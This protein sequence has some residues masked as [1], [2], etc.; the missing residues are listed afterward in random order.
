[1]KKRLCIRKVL[2][3]L[4]FILFV[5]LFFMLS[6]YKCSIDNESD[7]FALKATKY[8]YDLP[9]RIEFWNKTKIYDTDSDWYGRENAIILYKN[10]PLICYG[11]T[12][13]NS[14]KYTIFDNGKYEIKTLENDNIST[15]ISLAKDR[16][17]NVHFL[18]TKANDKNRTL[19]KHVWFEANK[20]KSEI[21]N[22]KKMGS[23]RNDRS[24]MFDRKNILH[25]VYYDNENNGLVYGYKS[26]VKWIFET[27][28]DS[29][30]SGYNP[31]LNVNSNDRVSI[32]Y[33]EVS[34]DKSSAL[35]LK[36]KNKLGWQSEIIDKCSSKF[37]IHR[38]SISED[39]NTQY[40]SYCYISVEGL[41]KLILAY[42]IDKTWKKLIVEESELN[43]S[44]SSLKINKNNVLHL[45]Y[46]RTD[47][48]PDH[49]KLSL[50]ENLKYLTLKLENNALR[51]KTIDNILS[52]AN[53]MI[54]TPSI[55]I[56]DDL[57]STPHLCIIY[58]DD[59]DLNDQCILLI[60][61]VK[62]P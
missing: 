21:V 14:L 24:M 5:P 34:P 18:Y 23:V 28:A 40:I 4:Y 46:V 44:L 35:I 43:I 20:L 9:P 3:K 58:K 13:N 32:V 53:S 62:S 26:G 19:I 36:S 49:N 12:R 27:I 8:K 22:E 17:G 1:M 39:E 2:L 7:S 30:K 41:K 25:I 47:M 52:S 60:E 38:Q 42:K 6:S 57:Q 61:P 16:N 55:V 29:S 11:D 33:T 56:N 51:V 59:Y 50:I 54:G 45:A 37:L 10:K 31:V 15:Q 48:T